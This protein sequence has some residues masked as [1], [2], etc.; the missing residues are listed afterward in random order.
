MLEAKPT[1]GTRLERS[2]NE[3]SCLA[4]WNAWPVSWAATAM[5]AIELELPTG[6]DRRMTLPRGS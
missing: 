2:R 3:A 5:A 1:A 4:S 6:S